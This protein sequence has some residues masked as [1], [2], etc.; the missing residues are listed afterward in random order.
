M[1]IDIH[2]HIDDE[3]TLGFY[4]KK[5]RSRID[6]AFVLHWYKD[7]LA[8]LAEFVASKP[9]MKL[10]AS[11]G[12]GEPSDISIQLSIIERML[13][14][15]QVIGIKLYPGYQHFY[16][17]DSRIDPIAN[18]CMKYDKPLVVHSGDVNDDSG[19]AILKYT[20]PIYIDDLAMKFPELKIVIAHFGFPYLLECA[21]VVSKNK[22]VYT[23]ISG[24]IVDDLPKKQFF[25]LFE[26]YKKDLRRALNYFPDIRGK[27]M[28]GT[29][30]GGAD[31]PDNELDLYLKLVKQVFSAKEQKNV[32]SELATKLFLE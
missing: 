30:Y 21:N 27:I 17:F 6:M 7:D 5:A 25:A 9:N 26:E 8:K 1:V 13:V 10:I 18:L 11:V 19:E 29:D 20:H 32:F 23:D 14:Q 31:A 16:V 22:N 4:L 2:T 28:F 12:L 24:T 15:K 3:P